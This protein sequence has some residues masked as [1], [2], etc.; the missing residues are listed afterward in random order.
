M[1]FGKVVSCPL[2][3]PF[4]GT[5]RGPQSLAKIQAWTNSIV[6]LC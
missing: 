1:L 3:E 4:I 5:E 6:K 2:E